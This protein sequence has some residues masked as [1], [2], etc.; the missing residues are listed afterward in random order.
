MVQRGVETYPSTIKEN[1]TNIR[2]RGQN[3]VKQD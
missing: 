3:Y 2:K 1:S